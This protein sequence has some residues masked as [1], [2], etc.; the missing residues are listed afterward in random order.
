[1]DM[2]TK[3][4]AFYQKLTDIN[5][6]QLGFICFLLHSI[7]VGFSIASSIAAFAICGLYGFKM[8]VD[9]QKNIDLNKEVLQKIANMESNL[10]VIKLGQGFR[11][12]NNEEKAK[13]LF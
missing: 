9:K 2:M 5:V 13:K 10:N 6:P 1:M 11:T 8:L 7:I 12:T 3:W 4:Q